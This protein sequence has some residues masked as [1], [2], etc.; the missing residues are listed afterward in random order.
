MVSI[1]SPFYKQSLDN[2]IISPSNKAV[3]MLQAK[4]NGD[5]EFVVWGTGK[6]IREWTYVD[7]FINS[8]VL[9]I[10]IDHLDTAQSL[11]RKVLDIEHK[12]YPQVIKAFCEDRIVWK[13]NKPIIKE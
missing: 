8:L 11:S 6:P 12:I 7:D 1:I 5:D 2:P 3:R 9:A 4:K 10:D 13:K